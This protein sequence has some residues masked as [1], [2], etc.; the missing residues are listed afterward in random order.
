MCPVSAAVYFQI[1]RNLIVILE[2][3]CGCMASGV[4]SRVSSNSSH[5][6]PSLHCRT[7]RH[8][9]LSQIC[10][11]YDLSHYTLHCCTVTPVVIENCRKYALYMICRTALLHCHTVTVVIIKNCRKYARYMIT[12]CSRV[13]V[14][15]VECDYYIRTLRA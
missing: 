14:Y 13:C 4:R 6:L 15:T 5:S 8:Q 3:G 1:C 11:I 2:F 12:S 7:G 10:V 9:K